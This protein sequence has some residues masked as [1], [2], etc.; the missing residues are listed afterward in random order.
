MAENKS[1]FM[2]E[3]VKV[4]I[5]GN[6]VGGA[7]SLEVVFEQENKPLGEAGT[8]KKREIMSGP[9]NI[10]GSV[11]RLFLEPS[12]LTD[13]IDIENGDSPYFQISGT[14]VNK[15]PQRTISIIDAKFKGFTISM[16]LGEETKVPQD[17]EA[18]DIKLS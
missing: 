9:I 7:Q 6:I 13:H 15:E 8:K 3:D 17:F 2:L 10:T 1:S 12:Q 14:T 18:L 11:E 4:S 5:D 16:A